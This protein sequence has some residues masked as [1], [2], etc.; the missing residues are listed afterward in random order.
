MIVR[1]NLTCVRKFPGGIFILPTIN[2]IDDMKAKLL[3]KND[4]FKAHVDKGDFQILEVDSIDDVQDTDSIADAVMEANVEDAKDLI[5]ELADIGE[6][7]KI[8]KV[9][10]RK[11]VKKAAK[12]KLEELGAIKDEDND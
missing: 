3:E 8:L 7:K 9:D 10:R 4:A 6:L 5:E 2:Q 1:S 11:T 12:A